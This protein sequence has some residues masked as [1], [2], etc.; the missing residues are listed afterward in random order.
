MPT[1]IY[2]FKNRLNMTFSD[3]ED[4]KPTQRIEV[5]APP[6]LSVR[7]SCLSL[8]PSLPLSL[9]ATPPRGPLSAAI[10]VHKTPSNLT[11]ETMTPRHACGDTPHAY[12]RTFP[13]R[14]PLPHA[15]RIAAVRHC[16]CG[17]T[18]QAGG[19]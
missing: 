15:D 1:S 6:R 13:A 16:M 9:P 17:A 11:W 7:P 10:P 19:L 4:I 5:P 2:I 18:A 8:H 3:C 12:T 14:R